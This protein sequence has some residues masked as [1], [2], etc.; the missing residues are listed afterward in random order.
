MEKVVVALAAHA[1]V[2]AIASA[3]VLMGDEPRDCDLGRCTDSKGEPPATVTMRGADAGRLM[4]RVMQQLMR[5][6]FSR[7]LRVHYG[8]TATTALPTLPTLPTAP[9]RRYP[10]EVTI[11]A[12]AARAA[13]TCSPRCPPAPTRTPRHR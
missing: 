4:Q 9:R 11:R 12:R 1:F 13:P 7:N 5:G 3:L 8:A 10:T 2:A 6:G